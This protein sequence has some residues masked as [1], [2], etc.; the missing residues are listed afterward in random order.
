[1]GKYPDLQDTV[2]VLDYGVKQE[3]MKQRALFEKLAG[4]WMGKDKRRGVPYIWSV[5][6]L[7]DGNRRTSPRSF[8][9][10]IRAAAEY[11]MGKESDYPLHY[12][13]IKQGVQK[14][15]VVRMGELT[16]EDYPWVNEIIVPLQ[17]LNVPIDFETIQDRWQRQFP[18]GY[19]PGGLPPE[20]LEQGWNGIKDDLIQLGIFETMYDGRIN[21]PDLYRVG[22]KL[23]RKGGVKPV[24]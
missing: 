24:K 3:G 10:A 4:P 20:H 16:N 11:S 15:A 19:K 2:W 1:V 13:G 23:G 8:L 6:H 9:T 21:M 7:A 17:G 14:A 18:G 5:S 12:D 22:F